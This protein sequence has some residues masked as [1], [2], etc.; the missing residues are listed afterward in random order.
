MFRLLRTV[1]GRFSRTNNT[2]KTIEVTPVE[3]NRKL[4]IFDPQT[5][6]RTWV[7][8]HRSQLRDRVAPNLEE[9]PFENVYL[10]RNEV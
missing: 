2:I 7:N 3:I 1:V 8:Q 4:G 5:L 9:L 6:H 10:E